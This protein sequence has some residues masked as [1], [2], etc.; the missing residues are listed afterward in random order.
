MAELIDTGEKRD[1][2]GRRIVT[3]KQRE[4]LL[5]AYAQSGLTQRVFAEREGIKYHTLVDWL[6][7][8]RQ[9]GDAAKPGPR[10][11][12]LRLGPIGT[13]ARAAPLEVAL[14]NGLVVRG[15]NA[16]AMAALVRALLEGA[17]C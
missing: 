13:A 17:P 15:T 9:R 6:A 1:E 4:L 12:E 2:R 10:F 8:A 5:A 7:Q 11:Q 14:P 3:T 16:T